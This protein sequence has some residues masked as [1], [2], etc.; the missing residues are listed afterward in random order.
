MNTISTITILPLSKEQRGKYIE[1]V[2]NEF[3]HLNEVE[4]Q[5]LFSQMKIVIKTMEAIMEHKDVRT[6]IIDRMDNNK[7]ENEYAEITLSNRKTYGFEND[8]KWCELQ[9][10][11]EFLKD[12]QKKHE[13]LLKCLKEQVANT[14]TGEVMTPAYIKSQIEVLTIKLK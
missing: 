11:I 13:G 10:K 12:E 8:E 3:N 14:E 1:Q 4:Q 2:V 7:I 5:K 6:A 9:K